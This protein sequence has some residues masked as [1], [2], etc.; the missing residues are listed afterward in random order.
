MLNRKTTIPS[1]FCQLARFIQIDKTTSLGWRDRQEEL[2]VL[3][4]LIIW[5]QLCKMTLT[6]LIQKNKSK[7]V[8]QTV[9]EKVD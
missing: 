3:I 7:T 6:N 4:L 5:L 2:V 1:D 8:V 9:L